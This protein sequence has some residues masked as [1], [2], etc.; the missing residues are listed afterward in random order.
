[1]LQ[2]E[3]HQSHV[4]HFIWGGV[5][6][7]LGFFMIVALWIDSSRRYQIVENM[8]SAKCQG[9]QDESRTTGQV[10]RVYS[11]HRGTLQKAG[12][13]GND[14]GEVEMRKLPKPPAAANP[15][16]LQEGSANPGSGD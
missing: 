3:I 15:P 14:R 2:V 13:P 4:K 16:S 8:H 6:L 7:I 9:R 10:P 1:M 12:A 11:K 5:T